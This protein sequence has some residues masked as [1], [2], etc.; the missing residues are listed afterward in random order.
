MVAILSRCFT[1]RTG[2]LNKSIGKKGSSFGIVELFNFLFFHQARCPNFRPNL[3]TQL[4]ILITVRAAIVVELDIES[5]KIALM[6]FVRAG[7]EFLFGHALLLRADHDR[8]AV[9][10][11]SAE[12]DAAIA[13][14]LLKPHPNVSLNV[15]NQVPDMDRAVGIRQ[16]GGDKDLTQRSRAFMKVKGEW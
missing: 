3:A 11:I 7:N 10:V 5:G 14:Q 12:I 15:F 9:R 13:T 16:S 2:P 1:I 6:F 4:P 8:R